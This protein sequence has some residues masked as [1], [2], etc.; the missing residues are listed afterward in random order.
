MHNFHALSALL[1]KL[2]TPRLRL[3]PARPA[4]GW[5]LF[6]ASRTPAFNKYLMWSQPE[7][8]YNAVRRME[9]ISIAH[10]SGRM[11]AFSA[12]HV[13]TGA[14][15]ALFRFMPYGQDPSVTEMGLWIH[16]NFW[17]SDYGT[18]LT[19]ACVSTALRLPQIRTLLA[20]TYPENLGA[21]KVLEN[22]GLA[23]E[24]TVPRRHEDGHFVS[25]L[26]HRIHR[27]EWLQRQGQAMSTGD[28]QTKVRD[29]LTEVIVEK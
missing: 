23:Y 15:C 6:E 20:G 11:S 8:P 25:L 17:K 1:D 27:S 28:F 21:I 26:E 3:R 13:E 18:E 29:R 10:F 9:A 19:Q 24:E 14:W 7:D 22:C 16:P 2:H 12:V 4:D 5:A